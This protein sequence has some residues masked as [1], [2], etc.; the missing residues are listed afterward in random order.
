[1]KEARLDYNQLV[2]VAPCKPG[3]PQTRKTVNNK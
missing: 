2:G 3:F 1:M